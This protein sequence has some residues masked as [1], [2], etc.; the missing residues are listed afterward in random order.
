MAATVLVLAVHPDDETLGCGGTL[1]KHKAQGDGIHWLIAT[2]ISEELGYS[3]QK[4]AERSQEIERVAKLYNFDGVHQLNLPPTGIDTLPMGELVQRFSR[5]IENIK[6]T[7]LYLASPFDIHSDHR[8]AFNAI[9]S[10]TKSFR[11]PYIQQIY[12]METLS[13][14]EFSPP[15]LGQ[16]FTPNC[17]VNISDFFEKKLEIAAIYHSEMGAHPFP[18]SPDTLKALAMY[19]GSTAN[20]QYAESFMLMKEIR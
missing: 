14:S 5:I 15:F 16:T 8:V 11:Y 4:V 10:C 17:F 20:C 6:P 18:R 13:E 1:L 19:R 9:Y 7:T 3:R 2:T 12:L